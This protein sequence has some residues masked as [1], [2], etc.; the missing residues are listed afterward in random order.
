MQKSIHTCEYEYLRSELRRIRENA[1]LSQRELALK[2]Q[3]PHS[4]VAKVET[5]ERRVDVIEFCW[6]VS[7][8]DG[9]PIGA[10]KRVIEKSDLV[11]RPRQPE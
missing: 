10:L 5:G 9:D 7:A 2:L 4:W 6:F 11:K 8:C 3:V 1:S